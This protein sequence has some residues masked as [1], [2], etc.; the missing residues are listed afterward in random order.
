[1]SSMTLPIID[2]SIKK[3]FVVDDHPLIRQ[4]LANIISHESD[5]A[6]IGE[7]C[8]SLE[9]LNKI[10]DLEPD[11]VIIDI[12]LKGSSGIE[13]TTTLLSK[14]PKMLILII[15]MHDE[16]IYLERVLKAGA[17]GYLMKDDATTHVIAAIRKVLSGGFYTS[18]KMKESF[19]RN[20]SLGGTPIL[21]GLVPESLSNRELEILQLVGQGLSTKQISEI[22]R[23]SIKTIDSHY[24]SIKTKLKLKNINSLIQ[25]AVKWTLMSC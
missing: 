16:S 19:V 5:M 9:A 3:I 1:M 20:A 2:S 23:I 17:K 11:L 13:L 24:A 21:K 10:K 7:A 6:L 12:N 18:D 15:S 14:F 8:D 25:Y 4:G 22:L